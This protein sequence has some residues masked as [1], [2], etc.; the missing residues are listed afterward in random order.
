MKI[1]PQ[2]F[3]YELFPI[4]LH[5]FQAVEIIKFSFYRLRWVWKKNNSNFISISKHKF[6]VLLSTRSTFTLILTFKFSLKLNSVKSNIEDECLKIKN[7]SHLVEWCSKSN[8]TILSTALHADES[9]LR[10]LF[11]VSF[12]QKKRKAGENNHSAVHK[13]LVSLQIIF[14]SI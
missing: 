9:L 10:K 1:H 12:Q 11:L 8:K 4:D 3:L 13:I 7:Y 6:G 5:N 14:P 2:R